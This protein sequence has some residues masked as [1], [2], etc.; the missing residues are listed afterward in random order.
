MVGPLLERL[1]LELEQTYWT[2]DGEFPDHEPNPLL[3][4]NREFIIDKTRARAP[5]S[6]S[7]GTA[8]PT[9]ASSSTTPASSSTATSSPR[10]SPSRSCSQGAGGGDPLRRA[11]LARGARHVERAG[12]T[13]HINRVGHAFFKTACARRARLRRRGLGPLLLPRLLLRRLGHDPGLLMLEL[14]SVEGAEAVASCSRRYRERYFISGEINSEVA[15]RAKMASSRSATPTARVSHL[16]GVSVDYDDW[17]FNVRP[18]NTEPLLRLNLES[19]VSARTWS[20]KRDEVL[21]L[22]EHGHYVEDLERIVLTHQHIDHIGLAQI[23]A[24]R[25]G[26]EVV[27]LE[28]LAPWLAVFGGSMHEDDDFGAQLMTRHGVPED[29]S[30]LL[31]AVSPASGPGVRAST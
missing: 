11:R 25:S 29:I 17:H 26:A 16:D 19:L 3:P 1:P 7:P 12:G 18:S 30:V 13:A 20:A 27:S 22:A 28:A 31:R 2:P 14:L 15:D 21:A 9:A 10:C 5:T 6:A 23:L 24:D 4:E 8:T